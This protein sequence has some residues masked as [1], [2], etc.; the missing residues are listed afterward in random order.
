MCIEKLHCLVCKPVSKPVLFIF[1]N[2]IASEKRI[3]LIKNEMLLQIDKVQSKAECILGVF[4]T[5]S[6]RNSYCN[7]LL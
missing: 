5:E 7:R 1:T 3:G 6:A 2:T 4:R